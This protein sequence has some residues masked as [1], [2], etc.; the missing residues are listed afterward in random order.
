MNDLPEN[1]INSEDGFGKKVKAYALLTNP[2]GHAPITVVFGEFVDES[3]GCPL[4]TVEFRRGYL[5]PCLTVGAYYGEYVADSEFQKV[6]SFIARRAEDHGQVTP[7][8]VIEFLQSLRYRPLAVLLAARA[9]EKKRVDQAV[10]RMFEDS[11][12]AGDETPKPRPVKVIIVN[13]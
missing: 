13:D 5:V 4:F 9:E 8:E 6:G 12:F 1:V 11:G 10:S 7:Q 3:R 2:W